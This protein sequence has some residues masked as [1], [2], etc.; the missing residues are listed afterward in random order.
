MHNQTVYGHEARESLIAWRANIPI[1]PQLYLLNYQSS[2]SSP[3]YFIDNS[4]LF[5]GILDTNPLFLRIPSIVLV[6]NNDNNT[7]RGV[8]HPVLAHTLGFYGYPLR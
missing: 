2:P 5:E 1:L 8:F 6:N 4:L 3:C 7:H